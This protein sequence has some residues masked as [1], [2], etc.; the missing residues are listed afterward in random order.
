MC[1]LRFRIRPKEDRLS[2]LPDSLLD[3]ILS[4]LPTKHAVA[5]SI[6]SKRWKPLW[7]SQLSL[8]FDDRSFPSTFSFCQF[9][10]S[11]VTM[12]LRDSIL[13]ILS[14]HLHFHY[15]FCDKDF[16]N[17][18]YVPITRGVQTL[19]ISHSDYSPALPSFVLTSV[20]LSVLKLK[21][22]K[23]N[24]VPCVDLPSLKVLRMKRVTFT[25]YA[26]L[27][28]L[29]SGCPILEELE[30]KD[31]RMKIPNQT[32][33]LGFAISNLVRANISSD[34]MIGLQ[35]LHNV[36]HLRIQLNWKPI[37]SISGMF[38]N[39]THLELM[40]NFDYP[41]LVILKWPWLVKLLKNSPNLQTL[42]ID[43]VFNLTRCYVNKWEDPEVVPECLLSHFTTCE[44]RNYTHINCEL[45]FAKYIMQNS[46]VL[47]TMAIQTANYVDKN[48]KLQMLIELSSCPRI[49]AACKLLFT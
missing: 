24:D 20:T 45:P 5:T 17:F 28:K 32:Y 29:L 40:F 38:H 33:D 46:R 41:S 4:F 9:F 15:L 35:W 1:L 42:I 2:A 23:L 26:Y 8:Y 30:T 10:Y 11:F 44:L 36:E 39:L 49:S 18:L 48:T 37:T 25:C 31:L 34:I 14:F 27:Q 47:S 16:Y 19:I 3:H 13:P 6:L 22:I 43:Q 7:R 21:R 12:R